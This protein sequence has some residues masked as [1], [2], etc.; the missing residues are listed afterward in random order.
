[1]NNLDELEREL[2][3]GLKLVLNAVL[4]PDAATG[5]A[6]ARTP[7]RGRQARHPARRQA[8]GATRA[9]GAASHRRCRNRSG[10]R[11]TRG[12]CPRSPGVPHHRHGPAA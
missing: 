1:M 9:V 10:R 3:P 8:S 4:E 2:G 11:G 6:P 7:H 5:D 12:C